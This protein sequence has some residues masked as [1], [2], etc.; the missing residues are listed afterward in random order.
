MASFGIFQK[1]IRSANCRIR[2][3]PAVVIFPNVDEL[4]TLDPG[5][6]KC[7][8]LNKLKKSPRRSNRK[9][10]VAAKVFCSDQSTLK[11]AVPR[12]RLRDTS[13]KVPG[14][15]STIAFVLKY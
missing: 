4:L 12:I 14:A 15:F 1:W 2:G 11:N 3:S 9:R 13:P 5:A 8:L 7:T 10:S 6:F